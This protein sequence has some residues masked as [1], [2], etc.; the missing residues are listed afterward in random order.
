METE[1]ETAQRVFKTWDWIQFGSYGRNDEKESLVWRVI[2]VKESQLLLISQN[3]IMK[4]LFDTDP[5]IDGG[6]NR[7][8]DSTLRHWLNS[9]SPQGEVDFGPHPMPGKDFDE[10]AYDNE[11]GFLNSFSDEEKGILL[12]TAIKTPVSKELGG[13]NDK[14]EDAVFIITHKEYKKLPEDIKTGIPSPQ[15]IKDYNVDAGGL[16]QYWARTPNYGINGVYI[17]NHWSK[18]PM[19]MNSGADCSWGIRPCVYVNGQAL[20]GLGTEAEP[21]II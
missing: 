12:T 1:A 13:G 11:A 20:E 18:S 15:Y 2:A 7:W 9:N 10:L 8:R 16:H 5:E 19:A 14:T 3:I 4:K 17:V 6:C 21:F